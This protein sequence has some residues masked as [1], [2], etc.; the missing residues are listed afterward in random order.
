[1]KLTNIKISGYKSIDELEFSINPLNNSNTFILLGKNEVGKSNVLEAMS[2]LKQFNEKNEINFLKIRNQKTEPKSVSVFYTMETENIDSCKKYISDKIPMSKD[3][4]AKIKVV[5]SIKEVCVKI[6]ENG[7]DKIWDIEIEE[8]PLDNVLYSEAEK[9]ITIPAT[10]GK[11][12]HQQKEKTISISNKK[13]IAETELE[14][15]SPLEWDKF[16]EYVL[17]IIEEYFEQNE[18]TVSTWSASHDYLIQNEIPLKEFA[19]NPRKYPPLRNI[20]YVSGYKNK[21][22][23]SQ[24]ITN[25]E[26]SS[27]YRAKLKRKLSENTTKYINEKWPEASVIIDVDITDGLNIH[28][29]VQDKDNKDSFFGMIDRSQG[30]Q[31]FVSLL[32]SISVLNANNSMKNNLILIDEPEVH[33][34]PSGIRWM[35]Q[36]LL[37]IGENNY[38][39]ISSHSNFMMDSTT[40]ER[41]YLISKEKGHETKAKQ[42]C[43]YE[44]LRDEE[45]LKTAFGINVIRDFISENKL[46][47]EGKSDK[48]LIQKALDQR[49]EKCKDILITNGR[50]DNLPGITSIMSYQDV[51]PIVILDDDDE[52]KK[53]KKGVLAI[54]NKF[55]KNN[56]FT[57]RDLNGNIKNGGTIEDTLPKSY[58]ESKTNEILKTETARVIALNDNE[59]F[60]EQIKKHLNISIVETDMINSKKA[61]KEEKVKIKED[62]K[63]RIDVLIE[64]IKCKISEDYNKSN[65]FEKAPLLDDL[66]KNI[67]SKFN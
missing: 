13:D 59:P 25:I 34:H 36:E 20:F 63:E 50:G 2:V 9:I 61:T 38:L 52:G 39:F 6:N 45:I 10:A 12:Q 27:S 23:I 53:M 55:N 57:I 30:F 21:E 16:L 14:K 47:V 1:M 37:K 65:I 19:E 15:F 35:L 67:L 26:N 46:L 18:I 60:I 49:A 62:K 64:K 31:N 51:Y 56:V 58:I 22:E 42:I 7:F 48:V 33:L 40:K 4:L 28:I 43:S 54:G 3:V 17:P 44:D 11:P 29:Q 8:F 32:L 5:K 66:A 41:H 24:E